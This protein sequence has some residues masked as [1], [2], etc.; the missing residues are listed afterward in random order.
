MSNLFMIMVWNYPQ[1]TPVCIFTCVC[2]CACVCLCVYPSIEETCIELS[3]AIE[4]GDMQSAS[5][6]ASTLAQQHA[7]LQIQPSAR[8]YEDNEIRCGS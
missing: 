4:A 7:A 5:V 2:V 1:Y 6:L 3:H 8:D